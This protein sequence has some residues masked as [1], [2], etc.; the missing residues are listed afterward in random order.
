MYLIVSKASVQG[1]N[2]DCKCDY[3]LNLIFLFAGS[4]NNMCKI[5]LTLGQDVYKN[6]LKTTVKQLDLCIKILTVR[7]VWQCRKKFVHW[8][9]SR[10]DSSKSQVRSYFFQTYEDNASLGRFPH[11]YWQ[12]TDLSK[13]IIQQDSLEEI[14]S[15]GNE[16]KCCVCLEGGEDF[17]NDFAIFLNCDHVVC[18]PCSEQ[19]LFNNIKYR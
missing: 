18:V 2:S 6:K 1:L 10:A 7:Y 11:I 12:G 14:F 5:I 19:L 3:E 8:R 16:E 15:T 9:K 4:L 17:L 13:K